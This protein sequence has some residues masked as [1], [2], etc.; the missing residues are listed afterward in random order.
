M[1]ALVWDEDVKRRFKAGVDH[2]VLGVRDNSGQYKAPVAWNGVKSIKHSPD[3]GEDSSNWADNIDYGGVPSS[4]SLKLTIECFDVPKEFNEC[5][6][7]ANLNGTNGG[8]I[9]NQPDSYFGIAWREDVGDAAG[10]MHGH[11]I[12]VVFNNHAKAPERESN[13]RSDSTDLQSIS[14]ECTCK[15]VA[16]TG[17]APTPDFEINSL[18]DPD[19]YT[20]VEHLIMTGDSPKFP[21]LAELLATIKAA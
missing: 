1:A 8:L 19:G 16:V 7:K 20:K 4:K 2:V 5:I 21:T 12:S 17:F 11:S 3:G 18:D 10:G 14:L 6:G 13:T 15:P 9:S